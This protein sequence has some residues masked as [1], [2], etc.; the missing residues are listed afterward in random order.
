M[1]PTS[2]RPIGVPTGTALP[3]GDQHLL[4][5]SGSRR[6]DVVGDLVGLDD[7]DDVAGLQSGSP[8]ATSQRATVPSV[9]VRPSL[10][11][12]KSVVAMCYRR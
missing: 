5:N 3:C 8:G 12:T 7:Q 6:L 9:I 10:G 1:S 4:K 2:Q 11:M